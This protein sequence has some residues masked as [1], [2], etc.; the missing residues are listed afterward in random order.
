MIPAGRIG[1]DFY[2][3]LQPAARTVLA[4][5]GDVSGKG[6]PAALILSSLKTLFRTIARETVDPAA[7]AER[8]SAAL[9][10]EHAGLPYATAIVARFEA[11]PGRMAFVNAGHPAG[12]VLRK[13]TVSVAFE[14]GGPPLGLFPGTRY[15][16]ADV[17]LSPG[18]IGVLVTD[19]ITEALEAGPMTL[20]QAL[21]ATPGALHRGPLARRDLRLP[22]A[23]GG[24]R[25]GPGGRSGLAGRPDRVR[26]RRRAGSVNGRLVWSAPR[27]EG[28]LLI[29][30]A[31]QRPGSATDRT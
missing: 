28:I 18:D 6:I 10:E 11:G 9:H 12:Y 31:G 1:G 13:G 23:G 22:P 8:I 16:A 3:F 27:A 14:S 25:P 19:G 7:I 29:A 26:V 20:S 21:G 24:P 2:D 30:N 4:I 15:T 5:L 17:E